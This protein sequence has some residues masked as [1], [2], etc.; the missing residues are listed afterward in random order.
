MELVSHQERGLLVN[1]GDP[2]ALAEAFHLAV[3]NRAM[4]KEM[5][6]K[7]RVYAIKEHSAERHYQ[8]LISIYAQVG[9]PVS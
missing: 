4:M 9:A 3:T 1:P 5:G 2:I 6:R 7:A 8:E